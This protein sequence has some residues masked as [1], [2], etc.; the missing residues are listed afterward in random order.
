ML[1]DLSKYREIPPLSRYKSVYQREQLWSFSHLDASLT[2]L[3]IWKKL[4]CWNHLLNGTNF[5]LFIHF[6]VA[7][8]DHLI[9]RFLRSVTFLQ[10][11][12]CLNRFAQ[13][14]C[15]KERPIDLVIHIHS[16]PHSNI[17]DDEL[18][19]LSSECPMCP[20]NLSS[21]S[22]F[23]ISCDKR[24]K[25]RQ[26]ARERTTKPGAPSERRAKE[27]ENQRTTSYGES[28]ITS[29]SFLLCHWP[30]WMVCTPV[31]SGSFYLK[32]LV[33]AMQIV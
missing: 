5:G 21:V 22:F 15:T 26:R 28:Y 23:S 4:W 32:V 1:F 27:R 18:V 2:V 29:F 6:S 10:R 13:S 9:W 16:N 31:S 33:Y 11:H 20:R 17:C 12:Q 25:E 7:T 14:P 8:T 19:L 24:E 3:L 30:W